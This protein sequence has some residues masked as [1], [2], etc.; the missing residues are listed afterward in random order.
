MG[1]LTS[2]DYGVGKYLTISDGSDVPGIGNNRDNID[3]LNFKLAVNNSYTIYKF[4]DGMIDAYGNESGVD[5]SA[6]TNE[7]YDATND[8]YSPTG[9]NT[10]MTLIS[11][12]QTA[13]TQSDQGYIVL[14]EE[15]VS[16]ITLNTD[17]KS[18]VSRDNGTTYT[19]M[20]LTEGTTYQSG[21]RLLS[22]SVDISGQPAGTSMRY[23]VE[24]LNTKNLKLHGASLLWG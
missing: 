5:T 13:T 24:T 16:S 10:N 17:I 21:R 11:N 8:L 23:K 18:Y 6:S 7:T 3:L 12:A 14:Y 15:D 19:Q 1:N 2:I 20:T 4:R 22:G 9:G